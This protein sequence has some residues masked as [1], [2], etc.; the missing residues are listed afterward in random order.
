MS[1]NGLHPNAI[2]FSSP[3]SFI[4]ACRF[5]IAAKILYAKAYYSGY[6]TD[7]A[8]HVYREH[9]CS[10][11]GGMETGKFGVIKKDSVDLFEKSFCDTLDSIQSRGFD[12]DLSLIPVSRNNI[13]IDGAHR[14]A[15]CLW[16]HTDVQ[17]EV[18]DRGDPCY[19]SNLFRR[20][21]LSEDVLD[22]MAV[23]YAMNSPAACI[24]IVYPAAQGHLAAVKR[25]I[26]NKFDV[27]YH[28][29]FELS[30][31]GPVNLI[32]QLYPREAW[33]GD[34]KNGFAGAYRM[35]SACFPDDWRGVVNVFLI[36]AQDRHYVA[37]V[38]EQIR[39]FCECQ[40]HSVHTS[41]TVEECMTLA[42]ILFH[43]NS[44]WAMSH[45]RPKDDRLFQSSVDS[46][47][48]DWGRQPCMGV[49]AMLSI[50]GA[51]DSDN[52]SMVNDERICTD[53]R[54][55]FVFNNVKYIMPQIALSIC[56]AEDMDRF[57]LLRKIA[58]GSLVD[59]QYIR[60]QQ[61]KQRFYYRVL[62]LRRILHIDQCYQALQFVYF[63]YRAIVRRIR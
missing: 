4:R 37:D 63:K 5:D 56:D 3:S 29:S 30:G 2:C 11:N 51:C 35:A 31:D 55:Y 10:L 34:A 59:A 61:Y 40:N 38:K 28:K 46:A 24:V 19:D 32:R 33:L 39:A 57:G 44:I 42:R 21:G 14:V 15:A 7:W 16:F 43:N 41:D 27:V 36:D 50:L 8:R 22:A 49:D 18:H 12:S 9:V 23:E 26:S 20:R 47:L 13:L 1:T 6:G 17:V 60:L 45:V 58:E 25:M 48:I 54:N 53:P 62:R 52:N